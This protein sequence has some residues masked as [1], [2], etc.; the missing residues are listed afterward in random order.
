MGVRHLLTLDDLGPGEFHRV[1]DLAAALKRAP[2]RYRD[3]LAG[4]SLAM[5]FEKPSLR[6]RVTFELA[7]WQLGGHAVHLAGPE[8]G[9]GQREPA[10]D[11]ARCLERWVDAVMVRTFAQEVLEEMARHSGIPVINGLTDDHHPCQALAD[12]LT[13]RERLGDLR[14]LRVAYVGDG[15]NVA[16]SLAQGAAHCGARL[17]I[18]TPEGFEPRPE[19][20]AAAHRDAVGL[21]GA[22]ET[23]KDLKW[24]LAAAAVVYTDVWASMGKEAEAAERRRRFAP[25][26]VDG[27]AMALAAPG[28]LFMHC[29]P[30]HRGEVVTAEVADSE[31]AVIFSQAENRLHAQK[32]LLL[33]LLAPETGP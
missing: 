11:I 8:I 10:A 12:Y 1:L 18:V 19:I 5:I 22:V 30:A 33:H 31:A 23:G 25:Y 16:H 17:R 20:V 3:R 4:R 13:M 9:L 14:G 6:T 26:R 29:L 21:G 2:A 27:R 28:A 7:I 24:G 15:N 32:A